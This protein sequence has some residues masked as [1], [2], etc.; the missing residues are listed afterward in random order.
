MRPEKVPRVPEDMPER[1]KDIVIKKQ[2]LLEQIWKDQRSMIQYERSYLTACPYGN[3][4]RGMSVFLHPIS[5]TCLA[6]LVVLHVHHPFLLMTSVYLMSLRDAGYTPV[7]AEIPFE[8][9]SQC[10]FSLSCTRMRWYVA[11]C[12]ELNS[13][14]KEDLKAFKDQIN[15]PKRQQQQLMG[16][17]L[18]DDPLSSTAFNSMQTAANHSPQLSGPQIG[19]GSQQHGG[20]P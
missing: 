14:V 9:V 20:I 8:G 5:C 13:R 4:L 6:L 19:A 17:R 16:A 2:T 11:K 3:V 12:A 10:K 7:Q 1:L 18:Q 15:A